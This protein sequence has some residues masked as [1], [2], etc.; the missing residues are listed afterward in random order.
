MKK[1]FSILIFA[2]LTVGGCNKYDHEALENEVND[3]KDRVAALEAWATT[4]NSNIA[5]LQ[6]IVAALQNMDYVTGVTTFTSPVPGGCVIS[7]VKSGNITIA[8]GRDGT[9]GADGRNGTDGQDGESPQISVKQDT[10]GAYYWTLN[11]EWITSGGN[12]MRV[13]G[14]KG[15]DGRNGQDGQN[16]QDGVT[17]KIR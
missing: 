8:N 12:K 5:A 16:G 7:F 2:L 6:N 4:V 9:N 3:L 1:I 17:P 10:D 14:E 11:G 15:N 13:T